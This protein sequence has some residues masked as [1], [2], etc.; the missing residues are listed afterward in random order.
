MEFNILDHV[1]VPE[2]RILDDDE[3]EEVLSRYGIEKERLSKIQVT[4]P[5][6]K[7][8][9]ANAGDIIEIRRK[10]ET[11]GMSIFYRLVIE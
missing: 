9:S 6:V 10:S 8:I 5:V 3:V 4:D 1:I 7:E 2:H 11:A